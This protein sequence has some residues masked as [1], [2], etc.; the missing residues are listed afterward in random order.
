[1]QNE[2][3]FYSNKNLPNL[4]GSLVCKAGS[5]SN[6]FGPLAFLIVS[7]II[8]C[9]GLRGDIPLVVAIFSFLGCNLLTCSG[10]IAW[11][12]QK[13]YRKWFV[14]VTHSEIL[15]RLNQASENMGG[16]PAA[17]GLSIDQLE[18]VRE[19]FGERLVNMDSS[20]TGWIKERW[21]YL[22]LKP[23]FDFADALRRMEENQKNFK[24]VMKNQ[25]FRLD[26]GV[27]RILWLDSFFQ[28]KPC[29]GEVIQHFGRRTK[30]LPPAKEVEKRDQD[31]VI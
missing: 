21:I 22:E 11:W 13:K 30:I 1:M 17:I 25:V 26:K 16:G 3:T 4:K 5:L 19:V 15:I 9:A 27:V 10:L 7:I 28:A 24:L 8:L 12:R 18:W 14:C 6:V 31:A 2:L 23:K 20:A 29:I